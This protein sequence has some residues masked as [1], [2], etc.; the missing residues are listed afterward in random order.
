MA[1]RKLETKSSRSSKIKVS[2]KLKKIGDS[3]KKNE[4]SA[5]VRK[6]SN[7]FVISES[8]EEKNGNFH[9]KETFSETNPFADAD[10]KS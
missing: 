8:F 10:K 4:G 9:H 5:S 7:G 1:H 3:L 2:S 6:I